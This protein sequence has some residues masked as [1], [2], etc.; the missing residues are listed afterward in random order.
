MTGRQDR[1][2][3][4]FRL[5]SADTGGRRQTALTAALLISLA[6]HLSGLISPGWDLPEDTV[7]PGEALRLEAKVVTAASPAPVSRQVQPK[8]PRPKPAPPPIDAPSASLPAEVVP[9]VADSAPVAEALAAEL[10]Q[11]ETSAP[12]SASIPS[13][14]P[15][16]Q[17]LPRQGRVFYSGTAGGVLALGAT[18]QAS[19]EHDG[20]RFQ[21]RLSAGLTGPD[22]SLDFRSTG[23]LTDE[24]LIS[25]TTSDKRMSKF[26]TGLIDQA[27]GKVSMQRGEGTR[28]RE[29]KGL[30]VALS[31][32]PPFLMTLDEGV[33]KAAFFV[34]GD[35]WVEDSVLIARGAETLRL[36]AGRVETRHYQS[37]SHNGKLVD[38]WLAP[39]WRNAP[40]R[41]R[42]EADGIVVDLKA[43]LV[44][45]DGKELAREP[46]LLPQD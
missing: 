27:G 46:E 35:F 42:I 45:I 3:G 26:S 10:P 30:A 39:D 8:A 43:S 44:E 7:P 12:V 18:G 32:L 36:P 28:E 9:E 40:A 37:R 34:V 21:S 2:A 4:V 6:I 31:A 24:Q 16:A 33:E 29:I 38:I 5:S 22:S 17:R 41:I 15:I 20:V 13:V 23:R 14:V 25:E 11:A 19:W 1:W